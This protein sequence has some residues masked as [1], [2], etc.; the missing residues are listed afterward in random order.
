MPRRSIRLLL[1][2]VLAVPLLTGQSC[3]ETGAP[4]KTDYPGTWI[5]YLEFSG[6]RLSSATT[7]VIGD[8]MQGHVSATHYGSTLTWGDY[9][10]HIEGDL[11]VQI[12]ERILGPI[13]LTRIRP[14]I[15]T[16]YAEGTMSGTFELRLK[17]VLGGWSTI[18][19]Q[20]FGASGT[21]GGRKED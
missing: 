20:P 8:G 11:T 3:D 6:V 16:L 7:L 14:G 10:L 5:G 21:W 1:A 13:T 4:P 12:D 2:L 17:Q 19:G 9:T 15:D 18:T